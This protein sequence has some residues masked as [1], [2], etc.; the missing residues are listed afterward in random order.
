MRNKASKDA[1]AELT[2]E[3]DRDYVNSFAR[4][5]EVICAFTRT[6]RSMTL[7]EVAE[8]TGMNRAATRRFL[9]TLVREG[10]AGIDGKQFQLLPKILDLGF[11]ALAS[12]GL[13]DVAQ[14]VLDDLSE[15]VQESCFT[16]IL[17]GHSVI[18]V[19][20]A[21]YHRIV[22]ASVDIG[23]RAPAYTM[24][25]GRVLLSGLKE[26]ALEAYLNAV[27]LEALT[28]HTVTS[29][30]KLKAA[31]DEARQLGYCI[32]DQEYEIGL[33]SISA[34]IRDRTGQIIAALNVACPSPRF[35]PEDMRM[36]VLPKLLDS[37]NAITRF[38]S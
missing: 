22:V 31:I 11:S 13:T 28:Q 21:H 29:K 19:A 30:I 1:S 32:V 23:S 14:P 10:Y 4:G 35:T 2:K 9:L 27:K 25:S 7:S 12:L 3:E 16:V 36:R 20:K 26:E 8:R 37:A 6:R 17:D 38:L 24:S 33:R 18:Y 5:L 15:T 34:P